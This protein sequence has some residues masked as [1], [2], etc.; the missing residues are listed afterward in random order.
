MGRGLP[1]EP[2]RIFTRKPSPAA[3]ILRAALLACGVTVALAGFGSTFYLNWAR[4]VLS[5]ATLPRSPSTA[6]ATPADPLPAPA[7]EIERAGSAVPAPAEPGATAALA[8]AEAPADG[9]STAPVP[10][11][12]PAQLAALEPPATS[13]LGDADHYWV[14]YGV[15]VNATPAR[16]LQQAL[17]DQGLA[18]LLVETHTSDGRAL[19]SVRSVALVDYDEASEVAQRAERALG[20]GALVRRSA[21]EPGQAPSVP[22]STP[23]SP[24]RSAQG[25]WVQ[26]GAFSHAEL[27]QHVKKVLGKS[28][29]A[30]AVSTL[31][32]ANGQLLFVV[33]SV[34]LPDRDSALALGQRGQRVAKVEF[35]LHRVDP[36]HAGVVLPSRLG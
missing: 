7:S 5:A 29:I 12:A 36:R 19:L 2:S 26:F 11:S 21:D 32:L 15:F 6:A 27:A 28:G 25:Y 31:R 30:T 35:M 34:P 14:E 16:R 24:A 18:A 20:V 10:P 33:R 17:A 23:T 9:S 8:T 13:S 22:T 1:L 4:E 3:R